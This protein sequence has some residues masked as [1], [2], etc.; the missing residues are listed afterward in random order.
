MAELFKNL[1]NEDY[2]DLLCSNLLHVNKKEFTCRENCTS[3][4]PGFFD[5][6]SF[7]NAP[8]FGAGMLNVLAKC[9]GYALVKNKTT[10]KKNDL[11]D[12]FTF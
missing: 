4:I 7:R 3:A 12:F 6:E 2:I 9:N 1:Y 5:G 10:I 11:I 8:S